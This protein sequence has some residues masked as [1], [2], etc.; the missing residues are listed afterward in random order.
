LILGFVESCKGILNVLFPLFFL[1]ALLFPPLLLFFL[2]VI[3]AAFIPLFRPGIPIL[4][5]ALSRAVHSRSLRSP[6][7]P[8]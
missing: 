2:V 4:F 3:L 5:P 1:I 7:L 8:V 6:P